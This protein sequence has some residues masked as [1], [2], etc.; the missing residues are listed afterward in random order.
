MIGGR[1]PGF[2]G[3]EAGGA[4]RGVGGEPAQRAPFTPW[5]VVLASSV[6]AGQRGRACF[7]WRSGESALRGSH[8]GVC[9]TDGGVTSHLQGQ[10]EERKTLRG[11]PS[12]GCALFTRQRLAEEETGLSG[13]SH[14]HR[15]RHLRPCGDKC[16]WARCREQLLQ[17]GGEGPG[18]AAA[19]GLQDEL[20]PP[21]RLLSPPSLRTSVRHSRVPEQSFQGVY[22]FR[23]YLEPALYKH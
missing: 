15:R 20:R 9:L 16:Q 18:D 13:W 2:F 11:C 8:Q 4:C 7:P 17:R 14:G 6:S 23:K 22:E 3:T 21:M 5:G 1:C 12:A 19:T 10:A